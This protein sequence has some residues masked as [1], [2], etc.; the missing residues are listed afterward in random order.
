[1]GWSSI[2]MP[3]IRF[4]YG[5]LLGLVQVWWTQFCLFCLNGFS[6]WCGVLSSQCWRV[7]GVG[8]GVVYAFGVG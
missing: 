7:L 3:L 8:I 5:W 2:S 1:M 4:L 6:W